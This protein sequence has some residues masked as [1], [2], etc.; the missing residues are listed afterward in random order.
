[1]KAISL[2]LNEVGRDLA[3]EEL[4]YYLE[5]MEA[6]RFQDSILLINDNIHRFRWAI[7]VVE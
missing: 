1:M 7:A 6:M 3:M 5:L 4:N 2:R